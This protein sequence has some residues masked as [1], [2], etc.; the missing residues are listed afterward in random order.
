MEEIGLIRDEA[1]KFCRVCGTRVHRQY[2]AG[3]GRRCVACL[4]RTHRDHLSENGR[5]CLVCSREELSIPGEYLHPP[6]RV[7]LVHLTDLH[8][9][10]EDSSRRGDLL[11]DWIGSRGAD[12]VLVSG[13]L[14]GR[15]GRE[16]Y[17]R[18]ARWIEGIESSGARVAVVPGNHDIGYW[19][20]PRSI[21]R[22]AMGRK[23][24]R[25]MEVIDR[26]IEPCVR[27]PGCVILGLN[28]AHGL[29]LA[30]PTNGYLGRGQ[31]A[32]AGEIF[33]AAP[34]GHLRAVFCHHPLL[35]LGDE[36]HSAMIGADAAR[37]HL[38]ASGAGL[39]LWGHQHSF[40]S[41]VIAGKS[42]SGIAVQSTT[43]S[44]RLRGGGYPGFA[45][46]EW[47]FGMGADVRSYEVLDDSRVKEGKR[48]EY[49]AREGT[50]QA[51]VE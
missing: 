49:A 35:R 21:G 46:V 28:S 51:A 32:R 25:W 38:L 22:Q 39:F 48:V 20:N 9:G 11:L 31:L 34:R 13:D 23:Y 2:R 44:E 33:R 16:E 26:P 30:G 12:Y 27:G 45:S 3:G 47:L 40:A 8:F 36:A 18:A 7:F 43:L 5:T 41:A 14:T 42:G 17:Q 1:K 37:E 19:G 15:A 50:W 29:G 24:H 4:H 10:G 6:E